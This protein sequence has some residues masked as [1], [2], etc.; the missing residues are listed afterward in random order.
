MSY[1]V[2]EKDVPPTLI[3]TQ[4]ETCTFEN[5]S[6]T[7]YGMFTDVKRNLNGSFF[8]NTQEIPFRPD[9]PVEIC[10]PVKSAYEDLNFNKHEYKVVQRLKVLSTVYSGAYDNLS[11]PLD[12]IMS[13]AK[14]KGLE[15]TTPYR[16]IYHKEK[17]KW[18]R[19]RF[20]KRAVGEYVVEVQA[21]IAMNE[22]QV[23][24]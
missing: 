11:E 6:Q 13:F 23:S 20:F 2:V 5:L 19:N 3:V 1:T 17:R 4:L 18:Q 24:E 14:E 21:K 7:V 10:C 22:E 16:I 8:C 12:A 9:T 15:V